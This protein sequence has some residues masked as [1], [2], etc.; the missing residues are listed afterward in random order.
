MRRKTTLTLFNINLTRPFIALV[1]LT[2]N[3]TTQAEPKVQMQYYFD[4]RDFNT[5][6][7]VVSANDLPA[8]FSIWGFTD[9]HG[10]Q[11]NANE[12]Y[13]IT[14]SFSEY[15]LSNNKISDWTKIDNLG[16][17]VEVNE[18]SPGNN[19]T[20]WR[21][22]ITYKLV[23]SANNWLQLRLFP[24]QSNKHNQ[25]SLIYFYSIT[26]NVKFSGF[27]DYNIQ[28]GSKNRWVVEPQLSY[29][30]MDKAW[31]LL[32][33]RYNGFEDAKAT[34]DGSGWAIG[35]SYDLL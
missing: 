2:I 18:T 31:L 13:D 23:S 34:L 35:I 24:M 10:D 20:V 29:R 28:D 17:Q 33:Y 30:L 12:R 8:G 19:N 4:D 1:L 14:R 22:G 7:V 21:G 11:N 9:F 6:G 32:E 16:L 15:R 26:T 25:A 5:L 27:A 3:V